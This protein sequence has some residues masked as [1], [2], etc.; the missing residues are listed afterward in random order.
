MWWPDYPV[1]V[2]VFRRISRPT[3]DQLLGGQIDAAIAKQGVGD[4]TAALA[5]GDTW[6]VD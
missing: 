1:P 4:L 3:H 2:G 6:Q 5:A